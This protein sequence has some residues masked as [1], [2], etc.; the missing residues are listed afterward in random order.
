MPEIEISIQTTSV[1]MTEELY[2]I[3][4]MYADLCELYNN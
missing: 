4:A 1:E 2:E 3:E